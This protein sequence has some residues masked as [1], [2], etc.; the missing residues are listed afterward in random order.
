MIDAEVSREE[1]LAIVEDEQSE[2]RKNLNMQLNLILDE[3]SFAACSNVMK[4]LGI[5]HYNP[6]RK[7][8]DVPTVLELRDLAENLL[9]QVATMTGDEAEVH[10]GNLSAYRVGDAYFRLAFEIE[11]VSSEDIIVKETEWRTF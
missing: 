1:E 10:S 5:T 6:F 3:F 9:R 4:Q 2:R 8:A 7:R 11:K